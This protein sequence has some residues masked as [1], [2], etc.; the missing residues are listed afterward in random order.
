MA[1]L[2]GEFE[3]LMDAKHRLAISSAFRDGVD[4]QQDGKDWVLLLG[5]DMHLWLYPDKLY[6]RMLGNL[7]KAPL[8]SRDSG[9]LTFVF[10]MARKLTADSQG[11]IVLPEKSLGRARVAENVT[12][13][14]GNDH[15]EIWPTA[16]WEQHVQRQLQNYPE[17]FY[18][19]AERAAKDDAARQG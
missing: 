8:A 5:P 19:A 16:E 7:R 1:L 12:L 17:L 18:Q 13:V 3:C 11:R 2:V 15:I 14:G 4:P 10:A 6:E 9:L